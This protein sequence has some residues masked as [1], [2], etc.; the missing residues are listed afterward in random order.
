MEKLILSFNGNKFNQYLITPKD[1]RKSVFADGFEGCVDH[2]I[3]F[4]GEVE[5]SFDLDS[6]QN[7]FSEEQRRILRELAE[8]HNKLLNSGLNI[9]KVHSKAKEPVLAI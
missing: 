5:V 4:P 8:V 3:S 2:I 7:K 9:K 6:G 1:V